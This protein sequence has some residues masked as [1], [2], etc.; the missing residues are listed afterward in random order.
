M[1]Y[2]TYFKGDISENALISNRY[3]NVECPNHIHFNMEI[4]IVTSGVLNMRIR[5]N[6]YSIPAG[7]CAIIM[8][9]DA[10]SF[11]SKQYNECIVIGFSDTL[12]K[13]FFDIVRYNTPST[14]VFKA[15]VDTLSVLDRILPDKKC[16]ADIIHSKAVLYPLCCEAY[17][18]CG[19]INDKKEFDSIFTETLKVINA[20]YLENISLESVASEVGVSPVTISRKF[21]KNAG[22]SFSMYVGYLRCRNAA[23]LIREQNLTL[24][25]IAFASGFGCIR[26][27]NR[28]FLRAFNVT[29]SDYKKNHEFYS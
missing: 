18:K 21:S 1:S 26:S 5:A 3:A 7:H 6:D 28:A 4:V 29:P 19:F 14:N 27:F 22:M 23:M 24:T 25:E 2:Q 13:S 9:F 16:T 15:S 11:S 8:P 10:H 12:V 17:D 20:K